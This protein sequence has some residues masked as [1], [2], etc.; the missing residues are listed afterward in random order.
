M[1]LAALSSYFGAACHVTP[2]ENAL[3]CSYSRSTYVVAGIGW[4]Q[5]RTL[6]Y[7]ALAA[8]TAA[9]AAA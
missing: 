9:A 5:A 6:P 1:L 4:G 2:R 8:A 7:R 3:A